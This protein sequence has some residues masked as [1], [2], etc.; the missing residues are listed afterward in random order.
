MVGDLLE[1][2]LTYHPFTVTYSRSV[3]KHVGIKMN[4]EFTFVQPLQTKLYYT[5]SFMPALIFIKRKM[6]NML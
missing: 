2:F 3:Y 6:G 4:Q 1:D 5:F